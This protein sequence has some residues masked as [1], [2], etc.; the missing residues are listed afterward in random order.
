[1]P[2]VNKGI[3]IRKVPIDDSTVYILIDQRIPTHNLI[4]HKDN[5]TINMS[6]EVDNDE[7]EAGLKTE[8]GEDVQIESWGSSSE[9]SLD[10]TGKSLAP[11]H[12][13][14]NAIK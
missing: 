13:F 8:D 7:K 3:W 2:N 4:T 5:N 10:F 9:T 6:A 1:L 14:I 12:H 11:M